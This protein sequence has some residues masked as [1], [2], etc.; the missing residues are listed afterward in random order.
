MPDKKIHQEQ[1]DE[2]EADK[3]SPFAG[4]IEAHKPGHQYKIGGCVQ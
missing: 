3:R 4:N 1:Q 2:D